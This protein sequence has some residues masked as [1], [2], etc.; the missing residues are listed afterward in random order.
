MIF[1]NLAGLEAIFGDPTKAIYYA[2]QTKK[3]LAL[4]GVISRN[5]EYLANNIEIFMDTYLS[6][7]T[8]EDYQKAERHLLFVIFSPIMSNFMG[9]ELSTTE[10][11]TKLALWESEII[12]HKTDFLYTDEWLKVIRF[13]GDLILYWK[14]SQHIDNNFEIFDDRTTF[15]IFRYLLS[16]DKPKINL[17]E[18]YQNQVS[19]II[20]IPQYGHF[21][22]LI[23]PGIGRFVHRYWLVVAQTRRFALRN[24][25]QFLD[26]LRAISPNLGGATIAQVLK[27]AAQALGINIPSHGR[28]TLDQVRK[29]SMPWDFK[30]GLSEEIH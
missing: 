2:L 26:D 17:K 23:L 11:L 18:A 14:E 28:E 24:P 5:K 7:I 22:K 3:V 9:I 25:Q 30:S 21:A 4:Q 27:S 6:E 16:S 13:F 15:E 29:I 12:K 10:M 1:L 20:T 8:N 19:A